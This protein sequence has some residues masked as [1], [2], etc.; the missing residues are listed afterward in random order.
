MEIIS[1]I[2]DP[3]NGKS[4]GSRG[5]GLDRNRVWAFYKKQASVRVKAKVFS[6]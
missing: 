2:R 4:W 3:N 6:Q 1:E 5:K